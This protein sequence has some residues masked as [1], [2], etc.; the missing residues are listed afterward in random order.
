MLGLWPTIIAIFWYGR[1]VLP[2]RDE[3]IKLQIK[4]LHFSKDAQ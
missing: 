3:D 1:T 4:V 2:A